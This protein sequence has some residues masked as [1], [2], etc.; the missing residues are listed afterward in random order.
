MIEMTAGASSEGTNVPAV[1][2]QRAPMGSAHR[3]QYEAA[4]KNV[5]E[6]LANIMLEIGNAPVEKKGENTFHHYK[7]AKMQDVLV[8]L[9]PMMSR[10]GI[11]ILQTEIGRDMFDNGAAI[12]VTY[13]FTIA[14]KSGDVWPQKIQQTGLCNARHNNN[15]FDDKAINKCHTAARKYFLLALF[16][17]PTEDQDDADADG[18]GGGQR[19]SNQGGQQQR[20]SAGVPSA[21]QS[22]NNGTQQARQGNVTTTS[23][24]A[25]QKPDAEGRIPL[26]GHGINSWTK[27]YIEA[28]KNTKSEAEMKRLDVANEEALGKIH[29]SQHDVYKSIEKVWREHLAILNSG[30]QPENPSPAAP[31]EAAG[32]ASSDAQAPA[33]EGEEAGEIVTVPD[34]N[35][36]PDE[37]LNWCKEILDGVTDPLKLEETFNARIDPYRKHMFPPDKQELDGMYKA[38]EKRLGIE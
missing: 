14:H 22:N 8:A 9:T 25:A 18:D 13:E 30:G 28:L 1:V 26:T 27:V 21:S 3:I 16:Q 38:A 6:A 34:P 36:S 11:I 37:F 24:T 29:A 19:Q 23:Q 33:A 10:H 31:D 32:A 12:S 20:R 35:Q 5:A 15:K 2:N 17:V 4:S 7:Y